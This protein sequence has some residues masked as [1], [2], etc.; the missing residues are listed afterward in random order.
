[1]FLDKSFL[2]TSYGLVSTGNFRHFFEKISLGMET[3]DPSRNSAE[4]FLIW[5]P[6][7]N[8]FHTW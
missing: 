5:N 6:S 4:K 7:G 3:L 8:C 1:V 2:T